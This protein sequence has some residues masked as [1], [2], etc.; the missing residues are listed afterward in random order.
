LAP[1]KFILGTE[2]CNCGGVVYRQPDVKQWWSRGE[3]LA[4]D[5]LEARELLPL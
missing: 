3:A 1:D 5:I 2:A 4:L